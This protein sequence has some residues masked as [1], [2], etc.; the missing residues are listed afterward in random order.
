MTDPWLNRP[1]RTGLDLEPP[2][3]RIG[4]TAHDF[5]Q[6]AAAPEVYLT[7]SEKIDG[8]PVVPSRWLLRLEALLGGLPDVPDLED[9]RWV[10]WALGMDHTE[11]YRPIEKPRPRPPLT[12]RPR[13]MS[14]TQVETWIRDPYA[15][16]ARAI[17]ELEPVAPLAADPS[18]ADR[19]TV[20]HDILHRAVQGDDPPSFD[21]LI[22]VGA[23]VF[24]AFIDYPDVAAFWWP[25][26]ERAAH[27]LIEQGHLDAATS[28]GGLLKYPATS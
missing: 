25:R 2:E 28:P 6:A 27:W 16:F 1:M 22:E 18:A 24:E 9:R 8:S 14:V 12:A 23:E 21:S 4:L 20:I 3:R 7:A 10:S 5:A 11:V 26:F 15:I 13:T 19:G 17:L